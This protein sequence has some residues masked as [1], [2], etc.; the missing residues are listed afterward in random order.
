MAEKI[1]DIEY[2]KEAIIIRESLELDRIERLALRKRGE[3]PYYNKLNNAFSEAVMQIK[4]SALRQNIY[5]SKP[6][7]ASIKAGMAGAAFGDVVGAAVYVESRLEEERIKEINKKTEASNREN[8]RIS[9]NSVSSLKEILLK[10]QLLKEYI[11]ESD[12]YKTYIKK[13]GKEM[14]VAKQKDEENYNKRKEIFEKLWNQKKK[15]RFLFILSGFAIALCIIFLFISLFLIWAVPGPVLVLLRILAVVLIIGAV[16][17][18]LTRSSVKELDAKM[19]ELNDN[20]EYENIL[21]DNYYSRKLLDEIY[22]KE[23]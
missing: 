12:E 14:D 7:D 15:D 3:V 10:M 20:K 5:I 18:I 17:C 1:S 21:P 2:V 16:V 23:K 22:E 9:S 13:Y 4:I 11:D 6:V 8:N 19:N